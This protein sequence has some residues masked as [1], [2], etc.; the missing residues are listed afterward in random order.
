MGSEGLVGALHAYCPSSMALRVGQGRDG[1]ARAAPHLG[2]GFVSFFLCCQQNKAL[3]EHSLR[4]SVSAGKLGPSWGLVPVFSPAVGPVFL[5]CC[6]RVRTGPAASPSSRSVCHGV[7]EECLLSSSGISRG[8]GANEHAQP[9]SPG[10]A[11][12]LAAGQI[13]ASQGESTRMKL[14]EREAGTPHIPSCFLLLKLHYLWQ[15]VCILRVG[16]SV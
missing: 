15:C 14:Q 10:P 8:Q 12:H 13:G 6:L 1:A 4:G 16:R 3:W 2:A 7:G 5:G 9:S 11:F